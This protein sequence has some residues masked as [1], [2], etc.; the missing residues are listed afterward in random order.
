VL[1]FN[2]YKR[3]LY[4][5]STGVIQINFHITD[6]LFIG[7]DWRI[8]YSLIAFGGVSIYDDFLIGFKF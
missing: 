4:F 5:V 1:L 6:K 2:A 8:D 3:G 7:T